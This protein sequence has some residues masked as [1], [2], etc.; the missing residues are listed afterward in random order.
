MA[1][2]GF[3]TPPGRGQGLAPGAS[4]RLAVGP[5]VGSDPVDSR[6][7]GYRGPAVYKLTNVHCLCV[8]SCHY[9]YS[10]HVMTITE[11]N[12]AMGKMW[13]SQ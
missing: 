6:I 9:N 13:Q 7:C 2:V 11:N 4:G 12:V 5:S 3:R 1:S 8:F 10:L